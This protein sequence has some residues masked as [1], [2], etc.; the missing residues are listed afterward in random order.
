MKKGRRF[1]ASDE[2]FIKKSQ[3][4]Y[5]ED[6]KK[7]GLTVGDGVR[8]GCGMFIVL[9]LIIFFIIILFWALSSGH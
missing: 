6:D 7:R 8:A 2:E 3:Q 5:L 1:F 4:R 9:P